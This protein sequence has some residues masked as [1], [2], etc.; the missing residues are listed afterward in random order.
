MVVV[1]NPF[2]KNISEIS[3]TNTVYAV[4]LSHQ[5]Q[6]ILTYFALD[7]RNRSIREQMLITMGGMLLSINAGYINS[8]TLS[9]WKPAATTHMTGNSTKLGIAIANNDPDRVSFFIFLILSYVLGSFVS[10]TLIPYQTFSF[11]YGYARVFFLVSI[12]LLIAASISISPSD[13]YRHFHYLVCLA[14]GL[15]NGMVS[16]YSRLYYNG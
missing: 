8:S 14:N 1:Q 6:R 12:V 5:I 7:M 11:S 2:L 13:D 4:C 16:R 10:G 9:Y 3:K 15:Q